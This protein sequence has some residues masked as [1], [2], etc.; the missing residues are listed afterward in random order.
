M[1]QID[2]RC[3]WRITHVCHTNGAWSVHLRASQW[4]R[5]SWHKCANSLTKFATR[6]VSRKA[7]VTEGEGEKEGEQ[8]RVS[9]VWAKSGI[10]IQC[11]IFTFFT[12]FAMHFYCPHGGGGEGAGGGTFRALAA[13]VYR[14][15]LRLWI[16]H[17][18][19]H[20]DARPWHPKPVKS[21]SRTSS[22]LG[23]FDIL[24]LIK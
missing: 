17:F 2:Y 13:L 19:P 21:P 22:T 16:R 9:N 4:A 15:K 7:K 18:M 10:R 1:L 20:V 12:A 11:V 5:L 23:K 6:R 3:K 14:Q 8:M 24:W